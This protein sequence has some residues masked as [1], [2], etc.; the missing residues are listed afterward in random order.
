MSMPEDSGHLEHD[1]MLSATSLWTDSKYDS[2]VPFCV[3]DPKNK[4]KVRKNTKNRRVSALI[5]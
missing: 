2:V 1:I 5:I 4:L 3:C